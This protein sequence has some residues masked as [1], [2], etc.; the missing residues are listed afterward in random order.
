MLVLNPRHVG[1][2]LNLD[3]IQF[4][5]DYANSIIL[6]GKPYQSG[7]LPNLKVFVLSMDVEVSKA[8]TTAPDGEPEFEVRHI[9]LSADDKAYIEEKFR[10]SGWVP[11]FKRIEDIRNAL[12]DADEASNDI[13][14]RVLHRYT[15]NVP[16]YPSDLFFI[17]TEWLRTKAASQPVEGVAPVNA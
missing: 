1:Q 8:P 10:A 14:N 17:S 9:T 5:I 13:Y 11:S 7:W 2:S 12:M 3:E 15:H 16:E 4:F 6:Q